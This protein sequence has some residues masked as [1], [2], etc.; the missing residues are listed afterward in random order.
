MNRRSTPSRPTA[1][2]SEAGKARGYSTYFRARRTRTKQMGDTAAAAAN[3]SDAAVATRKIDARIR[4]NR[5]RTGRSRRLLERYRSNRTRRSICQM[6]MIIRANRTVPDLMTGVGIRAAALT[7]SRIERG[8]G[9]FG[10]SMSTNCPGIAA[11]RLR[12]TTTSD[13]HP[14]AAYAMLARVHRPPFPRGSHRGDTEPPAM[15]PPH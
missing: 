13:A 2:R 5:Q 8:E 12:F 14:V 1:M 3:E 11:D 4:A 6:T 10:V 9:Q 15:L 7:P